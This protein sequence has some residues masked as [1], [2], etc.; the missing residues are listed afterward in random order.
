MGIRTPDL[1][2]A[3]QALYQLSYSPW[4]HRATAPS[5]VASATPVYKK[6]AQLRRVPVVRRTGPQPDE[7]PAT[8]EPTRAAGHD[9]SASVLIP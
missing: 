7:R 1:L 2:H 4:K 3:M 5:S 6:L 8:T 9:P